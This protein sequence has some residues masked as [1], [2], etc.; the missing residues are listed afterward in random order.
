[1]T[2]SIR[3]FVVAGAVALGLGLTLTTSAQAQVQPPIPPLPQVPQ[4]APGGHI[5]SPVCGDIAVIA[6]LAGV[7]FA[8]L[9]IET[10]AQLLNAGCQAFPPPEEPY[11]CSVTDPIDPELEEIPANVDAIGWVA[12]ALGSALTPI[13]GGDA[14]LGPVGCA[15]IAAPT[16]PGPLPDAPPP[17][18]APTDGAAPLVDV[19]LGSPLASGGADF[20]GDTA[21]STGSEQAANAPAAAIGTRPGAGRPGGVGSVLPASTTKPEE[22]TAGRYLGMLLVPG[23]IVGGFAASA[24]ARRTPD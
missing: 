8:D 18:S 14:I 12:G 6:A 4:L 7:V 23:F 5:T 1:M 16:A 17:E 10:V 15:P 9:P 2:R 20:T 11:T 13:G 22:W 24:W 3:R 19:P 21:G